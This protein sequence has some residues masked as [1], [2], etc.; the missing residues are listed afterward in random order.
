MDTK[1]LRVHLLG[2][3]VHNRVAV[4]VQRH[5]VQAG[6]RRAQVAARRAEDGVAGADFRRL[7]HVRGGDGG[8]DDLA[9]DLFAAVGDGVRPLGVDVAGEEDRLLA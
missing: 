7:R 3:D 9:A 2:R 1:P 8:A 6:V 5:V 4:R